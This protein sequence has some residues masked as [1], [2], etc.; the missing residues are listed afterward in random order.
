MTDTQQSTNGS[1]PA[2]Q[3]Q[4][5]PSKTVRIPIVG[6]TPLIMHRFSAKAKQQMLDAQQGKKAVK[7][8]RDPKKEYEASLYEIDNG[9]GYGFPATGFK[10]ATVGAARFYG[11]DVTMTTLRQAMFFHGL[12]GSDGQSLV[13]IVGEPEMREDVVRLSK[14]S[15]DLRYRAQFRDWTAELTI[16]FVSSLL[17]ET[18]LVSLVD[19]G[20]LGVGIGDWRPERNGDFGTYRIDPSRE[21]EVLS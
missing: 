21:M 19:A 18:S 12:L 10:L 8:N 15:T 14:G 2:I 20:G 5:L 11:K 13:E 1:A 7:Q 4:Q 9:G 6:T 16:V 3:V 17:D